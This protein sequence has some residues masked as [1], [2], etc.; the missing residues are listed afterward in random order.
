MDEEPSMKE[1]GRESAKESVV[2]GQSR[3]SLGTGSL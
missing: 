3:Q 1:W 2:V